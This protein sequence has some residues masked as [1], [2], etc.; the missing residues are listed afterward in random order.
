MHGKK[1]TLRQPCKTHAT[2]FVHK[3][4]G[5]M[6]FEKV[7]LYKWC[8]F[9]GFRS[10]VLAQ[11]KSSHTLQTPV[12]ERTNHIYE[13]QALDAT[14]H[15]ATKELEARQ[16]DSIAPATLTDLSL[17]VF[18]LTSSRTHTGYL[19]LCSSSFIAV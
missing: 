13:D 1:M 15:T 8:P 4:D 16:L 7:W 19:S 5:S 17:S 6:T 11:T 9:S 2:A 14:V 18:L 12:V 3:E 10:V